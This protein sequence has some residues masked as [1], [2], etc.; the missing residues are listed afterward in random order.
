MSGVPIASAEPDAKSDWL[1]R[2][3]QAI[4]ELSGCLDPSEELAMLRSELEQDIGGFVSDDDDFV[5]DGFVP[6]PPPRPKR[7]PIDW[8]SVSLEDRRRR[9]LEIRSTDLQEVATLLG[10]EVTEFSHVYLD[11]QKIAQVRAI[12][13][14]LLTVECSR[15][16]RGGDACRLI[17]KT[18]AGRQEVEAD[19]I[20]WVA[21]GLACDFDQHF[22]HSGMLRAWYNM[23]APTRAGR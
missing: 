11:G 14:H 21:S 1:E 5:V 16:T 19:L 9:A 6:S 22:Q 18:E 23:P 13:G 17:L 12:Q 15:H 20:K 3:L 7:R 4:L 2:E 10:I 8:A